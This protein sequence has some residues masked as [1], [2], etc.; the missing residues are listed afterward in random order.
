MHPI[1]QCTLQSKC[2]DHQ[3]WFFRTIIEEHTVGT[4]A[5]WSSSPAGCLR[6]ES[7]CNVQPCVTKMCAKAPVSGIVPPDLRLIL[8]RVCLFMCWHVLYMHRC[9]HVVMFNNMHNC[10]IALLKWLWTWKRPKRIL[11]SSMHARIHVCIFCCVHAFH[12]TCVCVCLCVFVCARI[13]IDII[14]TTVCTNK[15]CICFVYTLKLMRMCA[16]YHM[17]ECVYGSLCHTRAH[18]HFP[19]G[20][21]SSTEGSAM[22]S[23]L[24]WTLC[25]PLYNSSRLWSDPVGAR[26][27]RA[28]T[29][30]SHFHRYTARVDCIVLRVPDCFSL[31]TYAASDSPA[32]RTPPSCPPKANPSLHF[33]RFA[34]DCCAIW[35][36]KSCL[37]SITIPSLQNAQC[38]RVFQE[39]CCC[40]EKENWRGILRTKPL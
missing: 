15:T 22:H 9:T 7:Q 13:N 40:S 20:V 19:R 21:H 5:G 17:H 23:P 33:A 28:L 31:R 18:T 37:H 2:L 4:G 14:H 34:G 16:L 24:L 10:N 38:M 25:T 27:R 8:E 35:R 36:A 6:D 12:V 11:S 29:P 26:R 39:C 1:I 32:G 3:T 30:C